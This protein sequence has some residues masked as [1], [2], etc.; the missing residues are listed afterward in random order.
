MCSFL[1]F[2]FAIELSEMNFPLLKCLGSKI[3]SPLLTISTGLWGPIKW[4]MV[5]YYGV[6]SYL[7][8]Y[9]TR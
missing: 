1:F 5:S 6:N 3:L 4:Q 8:F 2:L 9:Q 7:N